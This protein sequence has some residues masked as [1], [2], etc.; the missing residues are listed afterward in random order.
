MAGKS[1][2]VSNGLKYGGKREYYP[3]MNKMRLAEGWIE[4]GNSGVREEGKWG[5]IPE[6]GDIELIDGIFTFSGENGARLRMGGK[7][8]YYPQTRGM[9][10]E[11]GWR[12]KT[13]GC[14]HE[15]KWGWSP[16]K[17]KVVVSI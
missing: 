9:Y 2:N 10:L 16:G 17:K 8:K 6:V 11:K 1:Q 5:Y 3:Q 12:E 15:G 4:Y 7:W 13:W 14:R